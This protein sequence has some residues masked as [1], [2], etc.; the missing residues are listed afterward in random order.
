MHQRTVQIAVL[1]HVPQDVHDLG[2]EDGWGFEMF[3][4]SSGSGEDK[5]AR[6]DDGANPERGQRP[7]AKRFLEPVTGFSGLGDKPVDRLT[8]KKLICQ[9]IAPA[10]RLPCL[11]RGDVSGMLESA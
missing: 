11:N 9:R 3:A 2:V 4:G 10:S 7:G 6:T 5:D 1:G 8:G